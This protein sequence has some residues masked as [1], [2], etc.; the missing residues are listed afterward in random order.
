[1]KIIARNFYVSPAEF[2]EF[3]GY[4]GQAANVVSLLFALLGTRSL[5]NRCNNSKQNYFE[6]E[7]ETSNLL[8]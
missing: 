4:F 7:M 3:M 2:S 1:M 8:S 5:L 6:Q